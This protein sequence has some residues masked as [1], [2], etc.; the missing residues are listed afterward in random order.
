[1]RSYTALQIVYSC[2]SI[3][4]HMQKNHEQTYSQFIESMRCSA[5]SYLQFQID[6]LHNAIMTIFENYPDQSKLS[7]SDLTTL[8]NML[9]NKPHSNKQNLQNELTDY[10]EK[11]HPTLRALFENADT[12]QQIITFT[13]LLL[14]FISSQ[15]KKKLLMIPIL[16]HLDS[17]TVAEWMLDDIKAKIKEII[18]PSSS[19]SQGDEPCEVIILDEDDL[20][21]QRRELSQF[22][23]TATPRLPVPGLFR[24]AAVRFMLTGDNPSSTPEL[25][26]V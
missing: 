20:D 12:Q 2:L 22:G 7:Y 4:Q 17:T 21:S 10:F 3:S 26:A 6:S 15:G 8:I 16:F 5:H 25:S 19:S 18:R 24:Q 9:T 11:R 1:M 23:T 14:D 13:Q